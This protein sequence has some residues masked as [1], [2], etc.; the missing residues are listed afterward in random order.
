[1]IGGIVDEKS[2]KIRVSCMPAAVLAAGAVNTL[3]ADAEAYYG[4][5]QESGGLVLV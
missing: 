1:M 3:W 2:V 5:V 4:W